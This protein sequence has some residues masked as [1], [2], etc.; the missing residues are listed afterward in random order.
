MSTDVKGFI[1]KKGLGFYFEIAALV[2]SLIGC[3]LYGVSRENDSAA[4]I[5]LLIIGMVV[6]L[7]VAI[8]PI[9]YVEYVP[10]ILITAATAV[11]VEILLENVAQIMFK[12]NMLGISATFIPA[13]V[14]IV[15]G[16]ICSAL[17]VGFRQ[18]K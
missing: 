18:E 17:A 6:S 14:F 2:L 16:M 1:S 13:L 4:V 11:T 8:K 7:V 10:F 15:L 12:N 3:I 5:V 9:K